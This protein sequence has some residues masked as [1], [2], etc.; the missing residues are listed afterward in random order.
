MDERIRAFLA[1]ELSDTARAALE[2]TLADLQQA[3]GPHVRWT[4][5]GNAHVTL[6]FFGS[7]S[8]ARLE[9]AARALRAADLGRPYEAELGRVG[10]FPDLRAPRILWIGLARGGAE[11]VELQRKAMTVLAGLGFVPEPRPFH[12]H[13]TIGR[14]RPRSRAPAALRKA[15]RLPGLVRPGAFRVASLSLMQSRLGGPAP[16]YDCIEQIAIGH[17]AGA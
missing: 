10:A 9:T 13:V 1:V 12:P 7:E 11:T 4:P 14:L 3:G 15:T 16:T 6:H 5:A 8:R 17:G 2:R